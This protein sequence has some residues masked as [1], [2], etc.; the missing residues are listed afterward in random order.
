MVGL[1]GNEDTKDKA[2]PLGNVF[3]H[4]LLTFTTQQTNFQ[5]G[6][7][8]QMAVLKMGSAAAL[9][10]FLATTPLNPGLLGTERSEALRGSKQYLSSSMGL[11]Q[12]TEH[13]PERGQTFR[14]RFQPGNF[15]PSQYKE[16]CKTTKKYIGESAARIS[17]TNANKCSKVA[18]C[19]Q[20]RQPN[21]NTAHISC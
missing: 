8:S 12:D 5:E 6:S 3:W 18:S 11:E 14:T 13:K 17:L 19:C 16:K 21:S 9:W 20:S 4:F 7:L 15:A 10:P 2:Q 1:Y